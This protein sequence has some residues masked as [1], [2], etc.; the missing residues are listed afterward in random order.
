MI[1]HGSIENSEYIYISQKKNR[2]L[3]QPYTPSLK[4]YESHGYGAIIAALVW[5]QKLMA[6]KIDLYTN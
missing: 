5:R 4:L 1:S 3:I 6:V 2:S